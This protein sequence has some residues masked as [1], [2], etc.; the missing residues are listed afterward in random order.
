MLKKLK[1]EQGFTLLIFLSLLLMMTMI[2]I[3]AVMTATTD[4]DIAGNDLKSINTFYAAEAGLEKAISQIRAHYTSGATGPPNPLPSDSF[5]LANMAVTYSTVDNGAA[6]ME[7]LTVGA[8]R[9]L[10]ALAKSFTVTAQARD[11]GTQTTTKIESVI[12]DALVPMFQFAV[13]YQ[14]DLEILPGANMDLGGRVHSNSDAYFGAEGGV[15]LKIDSWTTAAG[16]IYHGRKDQSHDMTGDV[17]IKDKNGTYQSMKNS[18]G[19]WLDANDATWVSDALSR[20][21]GK[22]EDHSLGITELN[23]PVVVS[24]DPIDMIKRADGGNT[25]SYQNQAGL[26]IVDGQVLYKNASDVW[27]NVTST[28]TTNSILTT[29]SFYNYREGKTVNSYDIDISKLNTSGYYPRNGILYTSKSVVSGSQS[30]VRLIN[31]S[32][33]SAP[34]TVVT[35]NP[36]YTLGNYNTTNKKASA[37]FTDALTILS[38]NWNDANSSKSLSNRIAAN[39]TV[40]AAFLTGNSETTVGHYCG[41]LENLPRFLEDWSSKTFTYKGSMVDLWYSQQ[42]TGAWGGSNVYNPPTRNWTFDTAFLDPANLPPGVPQINT[43]LKVSWLQRIV[44]R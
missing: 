25:D 21:G 41:G 33:L 26:T 23:L 30:A 16:N 3:A 40:N 2:G 13:F 36:L 43:V 18:D 11:K 8:Y 9:G 7:T 42:A 5:D 22:V 20:W 29:K 37:L 24:G 32:E 28:F 35:D 39:T 44:S 31:G 38:T 27:V 6:T 14:Q 4:V 19:T 10:Y 12:K 1:D 34:L 15:S 17:T